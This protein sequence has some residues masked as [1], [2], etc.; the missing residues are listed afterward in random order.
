MKLPFSITYCLFVLANIN[1]RG[2]NYARDY[3]RNNCDKNG[4]P[5]NQNSDEEKLVLQGIKSIQ[6]KVK[7]NEIFVT[8]SD[9]TSK[10]VANTKENYI[11]RM[12]PHVANDREINWDEKESIEKTLNGHSIQMGRWLRLGQR[13][14]NDDRIK[15]ALKN[16][17]AHIPVMKGADKDHKS[18]FDEGVGPP[19][20]PIVGADEAPNTQISSIM[21]EILQALALELDK[22]ENTMCLS[23]EELLYHIN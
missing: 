7:N 6:K 3:I 1:S 21:T 14:G 16:K 19:L 15:A 11:E 22:N 4:Y 18:G 9:K 20:R 5:R 2:E 13:H 23:T 12:E 10:L 17:N 8:T